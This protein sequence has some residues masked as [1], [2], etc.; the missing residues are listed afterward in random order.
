MDPGPG[1]GS[2]YR[3]WADRL[4][5]GLAQQGHRLHYANLAIRGRKLPQIRAEQLEPAVA[6]EPDLASILGGVNDILRPDVDL[7]AR[8]EDLDAIV[9]GLRETGATVL[10]LNYPDIG[11]SVTLGSSRF[12]PK[13]HSFNRRIDEIVARHGA[14]LVDLESDHIV[15]PAMWAPD[16]LHA[17]TVGHQRIASLAAAALGAT[18]P[19]PDWESSLPEQPPLS[20]RQRLSGDLTWAG[21]HFAP[22]ILRRVRG[23]SSGD[24]IEPKRPSLAPIDVPP[25]S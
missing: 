11:A 17:S 15:H 20:R 23:I 12:R 14:L 13:L 6:M 24:G 9:A 1:G 25:E 4:A 8:A 16:R 22:W 2:S 5:E 18:D 19:Y 7:E 3:G 21:R 10:V